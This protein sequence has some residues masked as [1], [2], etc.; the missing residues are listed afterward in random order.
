MSRELTSE[1]LSNLARTNPEKYSAM[2]SWGGYSQRFDWLS[3]IYDSNQQLFH[4][5]TSGYAF[6]RYKAPSKAVANVLSILSNIRKEYDD[7]VKFAQKFEILSH[8][9]FNNFA[10]SSV[11]DMFLSFAYDIHDLEIFTSFERIE[12]FALMVHSS[13][14]NAS[15]EK[16]IRDDV[17]AEASVNVSGEEPNFGDDD[18]FG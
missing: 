11:G 5:M 13:G 7:D 2:K 12:S 6:M 9:P 8:K 4:V 10:Q 17:A 3:E 15:V 16:K 1:K 14:C 18:I